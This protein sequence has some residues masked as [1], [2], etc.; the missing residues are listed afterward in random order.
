M[1]LHK[2]SMQYS[3]AVEGLLLKHN[4]HQ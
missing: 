4:R 2:H 3:I 1:A